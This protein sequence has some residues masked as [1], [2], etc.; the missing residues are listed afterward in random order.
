M[1][2]VT[3]LFTDIEGSTRRWEA[4]PT[5][6]RVVLET[7]NQPLRETVGAHDGTVAVDVA[8]D[9]A[10]PKGARPD[11]SVDGTIELDRLRN[12]LYVGRPAYGDPGTVV[13]LF[14]LS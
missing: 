4:D 12:A 3:F 11:L 9:G 5:A 1:S 7:H 10:L 8:L 6:M 2:V 14:K 13:G